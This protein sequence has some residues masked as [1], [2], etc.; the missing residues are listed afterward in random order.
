METDQLTEG[1]MDP[2]D[3]EY[4]ADLQEEDRRERHTFVLI[5]FAP[6]EIEPKKFRFR[7]D[8]KV[9]KAAKTAAVAFGYEEGNP[10]FQTRKG[11]VLDRELTLEG[12]G[13]HNREELELVDAG[14]GV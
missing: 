5:I 13:V 12:A 1:L 10:S 6:K 4:E 14:G 7:R 2:E 3:P 9:G 8:E 11:D